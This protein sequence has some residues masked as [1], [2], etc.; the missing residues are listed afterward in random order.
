MGKFRQQ[1]A[2]NIS[3]AQLATEV[4]WVYDLKSKSRSRPNFHDK[5]QHKAT[6]AKE[7]ELR[8]AHEQQEFAPPFIDTQLT[9]IIEEAHKLPTPCES[10]K[11]VQAI[12]LAA[13]SLSPLSDELLQGIGAS[14]NTT[15]YKSISNAAD[16]VIRKHTE[17]LGEAKERVPST[18]TIPGAAKKVPVPQPTPA[19][20]SFNTLV[21]LKD[22]GSVLA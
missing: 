4:A 7:I 15:D 17:K 12:M 3:T 8:E 2:I 20:F 1:G 11:I 13:E 19:T 10:L 16:E 22:I 18:N 6:R 14:E 5:E 21:K 9:G